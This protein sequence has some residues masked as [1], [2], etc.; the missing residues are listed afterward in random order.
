MKSIDDFNNENTENLENESV[1]NVNQVPVIKSENMENQYTEKKVKVLSYNKYS[2]IITFNLDGVDIQMYSGK[3]IS[4]GIITIEYK[5]TVG[6][7]DF[8]VKIK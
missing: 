6:T 3:N 5:G 8:E 2:G 1:D 4:D 7:S